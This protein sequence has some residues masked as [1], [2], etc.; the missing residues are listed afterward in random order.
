MGL[1][2]CAASLPLLIGS[3]SIANAERSN[4][5]VHL[6]L[7]I[8]CEDGIMRQATIVLGCVV[9]AI[10]CG[11]GGVAQNAGVPKAR[12][13]TLPAAIVTASSTT[14]SSA[15]TTQTQAQPQDRDHDS[16]ENNDDYAYGHSAS[17]N[18]RRA[19]VS[20]VR[21]YYAAAA[22]DRGNVGCRLLYSLMAE[23]I[24]ETYGENGPPQLHGG[25][26]AVV[27]SKLFKEKH[28]LLVA[29]A[30]TL[31]VLAVRIKRNRGLVM[32]SFSGMPQRDIMVHRE[33]A[34]WKIDETLDT[35]L[36]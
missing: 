30:R 25:T 23:E 1:D 29:D 11:C 6:V 13:A 7:G 26:C 28:G 32:M 3:E 19:I 17:E 18:E 4:D 31:K 35:K 33:F 24:P 9:A 15:S 21:K 16:D 12:V 2:E 8:E 14:A 36:G 22:A 10:L 20:V 27:M 5:H 34:A